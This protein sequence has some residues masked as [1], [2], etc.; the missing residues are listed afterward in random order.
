MLKL[1]RLVA[2]VLVAGVAGAVLAVTAWPVAGQAQSY[3]PPRL[4][5]GHPDLNGIWQTIT[6]ANYDI[7]MHVARPA[8]AL[9]EGPTVRYLIRP[10]SR[11]ARSARYR[12]VSAWWTA[13][14]RIDPRP[15]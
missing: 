15:W 12:L 7:Q 8:M 13:R 11:W 1:V 2:L 6:E 14:S 9:R 10:S 4:A 3:R 5:D